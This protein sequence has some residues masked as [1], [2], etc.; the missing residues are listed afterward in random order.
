MPSL[1]E[2]RA[3]EFACVKDLFSAGSR[4]L[5]LGGGCGYQAKLIAECGVSVESIDVSPCANESYYP[6]RLYDGKHIP[7]P[8]ES[9][10]IVFSSNVLEH[11]PDLQHMLAELHRVMRP[12]GLAVHILPTPVWRLATSLTHYLHIIRRTAEILRNSRVAAQMDFLP[13]DREKQV[14][15]S[16][17]RLIKRILLDGPH[18]EYPSAF[19]ELWFYSSNR[20][21][22]L[23]SESKFEV[24]STRPTQIFYTGYSVFP[25]LG[26]RTRRRIAG[27]LGSATRIYILRKIG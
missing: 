5:E 17:W 11:I 1:K 15:R 12:N 16:Y 9:F 22:S 7:F 23:F 6:V 3:H 21:T 13:K 10:D 19:A 2:L 4:V 27:I 26:V 20:W 25:W 14:H 8:D 24:V 18:G